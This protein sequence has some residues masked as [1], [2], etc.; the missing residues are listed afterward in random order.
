MKITGI[1]TLTSSIYQ[2]PEPTWVLIRL[3]EGLVGLGETWYYQDEA[4]D[5]IHNTVAPYLLGK[6]PRQI[7]GHHRAL[8][9]QMNFRHLNAEVHSL[10]AVDV[11]LWD[12]HGQIL[13]LPIYQ[14]LGGPTRDRVPVYNTCHG[15]ALEWKPD[16]VY[17]DDEAMWRDEDRAGELAQSLLDIGIGALKLWPFDPFAA[18]GGGQHITPA[19]ID[20]ALRPFRQIR[21]TV[22]TQIGIHVEFHGAWYLQAAVRIAEALEE[23]RPVWIEDPL[24]SRDNIDAFA[25]LAR[26]TR[27]PVAVSESLC[28]R[29]VFKEILEK[30]AAG[31]LNFDICWVGGLTEAHFIAQLAQTYDRPF[32]CHAP[33]GP[34]NFTASTHLCMGE[35]NAMIQEGIRL[36]YL[37]GWYRDVVTDLPRFD[38]G[39]LSASDA[40]GLGTQL[41][42]DFASRPDVAV[43]VSRL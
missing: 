7:E 25:E 8:R 23:L 30:Q 42:P 29:D 38:R 1:E 34:V 13:G 40:P 37:G 15:Y 18:G 28:G 11:A 21:E 4:I 20:E 31:I 33:T 12:L 16:S 9:S 35:P 39:Y 24:R 10:S 22:G 5:Y 41:L 36:C 17:R 43:R 26:K 32:A 27:I 14:L 2:D 6:D 19:Q 3:D